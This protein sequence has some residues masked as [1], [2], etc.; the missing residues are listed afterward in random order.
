MEQLQLVDPPSVAGLRPKQNDPEVRKLVVE[1]LAELVKPWLEDGGDTTEDLVEQLDSVLRYAD[2]DGYKLA[3]DLDRNH[4]WDPDEELV[5]ILSRVVFLQSNAHRE[6]TFRWLQVSG[7][8]PKLELGAAVK[9][10]GLEGTI[11]YIHRDTGQYTINVPKLGH[12]KPGSGAS[13]TI[14]TIRS[15]ED[16]DKEN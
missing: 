8:Q 4:G 7:L 16:I 6:V 2:L 10:D 14:G 3:K 11:T 5:E 12:I 9:V 13:G 1:R 15:W